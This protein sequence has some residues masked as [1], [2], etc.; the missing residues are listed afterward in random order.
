MLTK[1]AGKNGHCYCLVVKQC[2]SIF[3][4]SLLFYII[5]EYIEDTKG[6]IRNRKSEDRQHNGQ[7]KQNRQ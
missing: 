5:K 1:T 7:K 6:V 2:K 3:H 4:Q